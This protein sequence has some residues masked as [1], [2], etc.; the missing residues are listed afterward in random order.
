MGRFTRTLGPAATITGAIGLWIAVMVSVSASAAPRQNGATAAKAPEATAAAATVGAGYVGEETCLTCHEDQKKGYHGS[1][2][3]RARNPRTPAA[4]QG[5]ESCHGP[6]QAH[7]DGG[8]DKTKIKNPKTLPARDASAICLTCH[9]RSE[10]DNFAGGKH[11]SRNVSCVTCHGVHEYKSEKAQL[12]TRSVEETCV[13]C[14]RPQVNKVHRSS[15][16]PVGS[17]NNNKLECT[18]C[19]NPHGSQNVKMLREGNSVVEACTSCHAE[20]R[21]PFLWEHAPVRENCT[22]CHDAHGS[23]NER[24]LVAK[25]PMLCQ[26]CHVGTRH[27]A[28]IYDATQVKNESNRVVGR[29]CLNCHSQIHGSNHPTSGKVFVR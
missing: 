23:N 5:C 6:G 11:D 1:P 27:P 26:R 3:A 29:A 2:H 13:Q 4:A 19:H 18:T 15:H 17:L 16:M 14:H 22:T 10:H 21:G 20:K 12:K 25:V 7:V 24:M 9:N 8:G 28:T